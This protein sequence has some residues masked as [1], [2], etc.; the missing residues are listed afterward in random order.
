MARTGQRYR[1]QAAAEQKSNVQ[2]FANYLFRKQFFNQWKPYDNLNFG[3]LVITDDERAQ[4]ILKPRS[5]QLPRGHVR[6]C[7]R[8]PS[9]VTTDRLDSTYPSHL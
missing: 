4:I 2:L 9:L 8:F 5:R 7:T 1:D 3:K 6:R